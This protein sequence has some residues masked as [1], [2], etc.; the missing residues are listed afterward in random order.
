MKFI[1][2]FLLAI[3][4]ACGFSQ[5]YNAFYDDLAN[6]CNYDTVVQNLIEFEDLGIKEL[7]T[8]ALD[9]TYDWLESKYI[10][11]GYT[12]IVEDQFIAGGPTTSNLIV[13]KTGTL[14]PN[15]FVI[16]DGHYDTESGPGTNDNGSGT[17]I[18]LELARLLKD[19]PTE[20]SIKFIHFSAEEVGLIGS[21]HY[22]NDD[23]IP[24]NM[25]IKV[26]FNID[27][28]GGIAGMTND[29]IVC[30]QD[31]SPPNTNDAQSAIM[32]NE[33]ATC[34]ELYSTLNT[35]IS[36]AYASD[37]VPFMNNNEVVTGLYEKNETPYAHT[38]QDSIAYVDL[39]YIYQ[40]TKGSMGGL[41]HF[42]IAYEEV[43]LDELPTPR[44]SIYPNPTEG[45]ITFSSKELEGQSAHISIYDL[46]GKQVITMS[47]NALSIS[48]T[49]SLEGLSSGSYTFVLNCNEHVIRKK[50]ILK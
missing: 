20:Y 16:I 24:N 2:S 1:Y 32:T 31:M 21:Q 7:G 8:T 26:V 23:V 15:T 22:V 50:I 47:R 39:S 44:L 41:A 48:E 37:Y 45:Q 9:D 14:Y 18:L 27:E 12:D 6:L 40:I 3:V 46:T 43:G 5:T 29:I 11:Y 49:M 28:V 25:D 19:V 33:L 38:P 4:P 13:T 10:E 17:V 35:E 34:I 42:A 36:F 30:E